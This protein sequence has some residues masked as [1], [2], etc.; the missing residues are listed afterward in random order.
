[1]IH[2]Q[3]I[4][5]EAF[6][7]LFWAVDPIDS[8]EPQA[9]SASCLSQQHQESTD[10]EQSACCG[11]VRH[12]GVPRDDSS[13][14]EHVTIKKKPGDLHNKTSMKTERGKKNKK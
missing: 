10:R 13:S 5:G 2:R 6:A 3:T 12:G 14:Y 8:M 9:P 11:Y 4:R 7:S 1:M